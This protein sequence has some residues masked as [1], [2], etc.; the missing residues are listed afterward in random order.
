LKLRY[1]LTFHLNLGTVNNGDIYVSNVSGNHEI[2][3][4]NGDIEMHAISGSVVASTVNG[5]LVLEFDKVAPNTRWL[6]QG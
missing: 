5:K 2:S 3:N 6:L 1:L 4:V